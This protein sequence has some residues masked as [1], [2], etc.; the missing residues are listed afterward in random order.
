MKT[1]TIH[2]I[3]H[4]N[5]D[6][7]HFIAILRSFDIKI[8]ADIR[9]IPA[10]TYC[11]QFNRLALMRALRLEG[12]RYVH[13]PE[14]GGRRSGGFKPYM[15]TREF[16]EAI[17]FMEEI[18]SQHKVAFMCSEANWQQCHRSLISGQLYR[19]GWDVQHIRDVKRS[20]P[21]VEQIKQGA[22]FG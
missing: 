17:R 5:R 14:L 9:S 8:L 11:P 21:H 4:S 10:S 1:R 15:Q 12:I 20:E 3:G 19:E 7:Q 18:G 6:I 16:K 13:M 22:L 2:S